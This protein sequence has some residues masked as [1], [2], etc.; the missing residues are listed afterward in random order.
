[1]KKEKSPVLVILTIIFLSLFIILPPT[2]RKLI[3]KEVEY[4]P[5]TATP[6]IV[7]VECNKTYI[8]ELYQVSSITRYVD[9]NVYSNVIKYKK[10]EDL[11]NSTLNTDNIDNSTNNTN[12][13]STASDDITYFKSIP[14]LNLVES[15]QIITVSIDQNILTSNASDERLALYLNNDVSIQKQNLE[16]LGYSCN[17]RES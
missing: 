17:I 10:I 5:E 9:N 6:K 11:S 2:F 12:D 7:I 14:N 13:G 16:K 15:D 3:P 8:D 4:V 1:M